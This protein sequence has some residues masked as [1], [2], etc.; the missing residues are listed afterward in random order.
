MRDL[1]AIIYEMTSDSDDGTALTALKL[2][3][4]IERLL[5]DLHK[6]YP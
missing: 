2:D 6:E 3:K 1:A 4:F 5:N